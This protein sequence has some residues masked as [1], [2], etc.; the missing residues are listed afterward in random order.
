MTL[1]NT[2]TQITN[3]AASRTR[4]FTADGA[5]R[6]SRRSRSYRD[7]RRRNHLDLLGQLDLATRGTLPGREGGVMESLLHDDDGAPHDLDLPL[8]G[9]AHLLLL[10]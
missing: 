6:V 1:A 9:V 8:H 2:D 4:L 10:G 3:H 7:D 5:A